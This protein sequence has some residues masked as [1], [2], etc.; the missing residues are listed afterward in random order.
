MTPSDLPLVQAGGFLIVKGNPLES[1]LL[2]KHANRWDLPKGHLERGETT[3]QCALRELEEETG[4]QE[5]DI[6]IESKF[7]FVTRYDVRQKKKRGGGLAHKELSIY[8]A[9]LRNPIEIQ[10]TEHLDFAWIPWEPPHQI[11]PWTIDPLLQELEHFQRTAAAN[12]NFRD[13]PEHS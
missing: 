9:R 4:I 11:Q 12:H 10:V 2:M 6:S 8:L 3:L 5:R 7:K 13:E 1:F